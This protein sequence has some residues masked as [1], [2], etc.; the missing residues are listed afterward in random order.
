MTDAETRVVVVQQPGLHTTVQ[1]LG[2]RGFARWGVP[3]AGALDPFAARLANRLVG[4]PPEAAVLECVQ[5]GPVLAFPTAAAIAVV[6]APVS[7]VEAGRRVCLD[8]GSTLTVG[9]TREGLRCWL[10]VDGGFAPPPLLGSRSA[11]T[12]T[13]LG[14][15]PLPAG[16]HLPLGP[17]GPVGT[18]GPGAPLAESG[19]GPA[20]RWPPVPLGTVVDVRVVPGPVATNQSLDLEWRVSP[21]SDRVALRL[22]EGPV[23][24][25]GNVGEVATHGLVA[26]AVQLPPDG[27]PVV[28]LGNHP[29][30][31]GYAVVAVVIA[32][33]LP[34]LAQ[35]RPGHTVRFTA[36]D[37]AAARA[38]WQARLD[39]LRELERRLEQ[40]D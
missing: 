13:G 40:S 23:R 5:R 28:M 7:G 10:A 33:D 29:V 25:L 36:V 19:P 30:T 16:T 32:A 18:V 31:G 35:A 17:A 27:Q 21:A 15:G 34:L 1:D 9:A 4:N 38:A 14:G 20:V 24:P 2:R 37:R 12:L 11:D 3:R 26:G 8:P 39:Q 6:G 22:T